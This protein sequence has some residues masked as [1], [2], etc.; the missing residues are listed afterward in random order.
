[1]IVLDNARTII[2]AV[3]K[4]NEDN[5]QQYIDFVTANPSGSFLQSWSWGEFQELRGKPAIRYGHI[6]E[7]GKVI[8]TMQLL[9]IFVPHMKGFYLYAPYGPVGNYGGLPEQAKLDY[10]D[11]WFIRLE[12][13]QTLELWGEKTQRT[14]P[15]KTLI[16]N[17]EKSLPELL[18]D[19]HPKTRYNIKVAEKHGVV[20]TT[21]QQP[22]PE[23]IHLLAETSKRQSYHSYPASYYEALVKFFQNLGDATLTVYQAHYNSELLATAIMI[24]HGSTRTYLFGGSRDTQRNVMA[25]YALHWQAMQ[26]AKQAGLKHYDW[27]GIE[28]ATGKVPGFVRFK[29]GWGGDTVI[30]PHTI[31]IVQ[32]HA[33]YTIY[34][35]FRKL[36][37]LF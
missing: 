18:A 32:N 1:M 26:D 22:T 15:G 29:L 23:I 3:I 37:R 24:D 16:T 9:K 10:P 7:S 2:M 4:F 30:Y 19:M 34:K 6:D 5:K 25:P 13:K 21:S 11:S 35:V 36:N 17:L 27:W 20:V 33:W 12:P 28:T 8:G 14:Q 31:D